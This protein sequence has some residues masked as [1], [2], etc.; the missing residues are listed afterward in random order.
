MV[1]TLGVDDGVQEG[2][3]GVVGQGVQGDPVDGG[4]GEGVQAR[5]G[6]FYKIFSL[7]LK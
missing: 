6:Q 3:V 5:L 2:V 1:L 4:Q 7:S